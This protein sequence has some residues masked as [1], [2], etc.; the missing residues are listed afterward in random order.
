[1]ATF[2][3]Y[4]LKM[5][6]GAVL[7]WG[8]VLEGLCL[9]I[10]CSKVTIQSMHESSE[11]LLRV[12]WCLFRDTMVDGQ[13]DSG[14]ISYEDWDGVGCIAAGLD[15]AIVRNIC[16]FGIDFSGITNYIDIH[17][18]GGPASTDSPRMP[19]MLEAEGT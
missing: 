17:T 13:D 19:R 10:E 1:V 9:S 11:M 14:A 16:G 12:D 15:T 7:M 4:C 3:D 8:S 2:I 5:P 6:M 18:W